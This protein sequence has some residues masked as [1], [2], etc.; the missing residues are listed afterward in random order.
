VICVRRLRFLFALALLISVAAIVFPEF[1][2]VPFPQ[3]VTGRWG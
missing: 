2:H 1:V 3:S